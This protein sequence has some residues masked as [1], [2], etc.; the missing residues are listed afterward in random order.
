M[1]I[2]EILKSPDSTKPYTRASTSGSMHS[3]TTL[4][5]SSSTTSL[6]RRL[7]RQS[8]YNIS[9]LLKTDATTPRATGTGGKKRKIGDEEQKSA[10]MDRKCNLK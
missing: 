2:E 1:I 4:G 9:Q 5:G 8:K 3:P 6:S 10:K 7:T